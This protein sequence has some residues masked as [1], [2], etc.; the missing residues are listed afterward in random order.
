MAK[1]SKAGLVVLQE[2]SQNP[3]LLIT[4]EEMKEVCGKSINY[5]L[6]A[7][8]AGAPFPGNVTRPEWFIEFLKNHPKFIVKEHT[9]NSK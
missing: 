1:T 5:V 9:P 3:Y 6:A 2:T 8:R 7:K 4:A